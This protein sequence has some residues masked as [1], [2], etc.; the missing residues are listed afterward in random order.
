MNGAILDLAVAIP[1]HFVSHRR[2]AVARGVEPEKYVQGLGCEEMAV[3]SPGEDTVSLAAEAGWRLLEHQPA[4]RERIGLCIV[5]TESGV[6]A[7]K[8][9]AIY[10]HRLLNLPPNCR[11]FEI[12]HACYGATAALQMASAWVQQHPRQLALVIAS[13]I[14]RYER[15]SAGEPT[16]GAGAVALLI[17]QADERDALLSLSPISGAFANDVYDFWRPTYQ[18]E[19]LVKGKYSMNCY[20]ESLQGAYEDY[21]RQAGDEP[22]PDYLLFH[23]PFPN[24]ARKAHRRMSELWGLHEQLIEEDFTQRVEP[25][26]WANRKI[27]NVYSGSLYLAL[28]S[29]C[30]RKA[31]RLIGRRVALFSYGSG[32]CSEYFTGRFGEGLYRHTHHLQALLDARIEVDITRYEELHDSSLFMERNDSHQPDL[33]H[34]GQIFTF[35]GIRDHERCYRQNIHTPTQTLLSNEAPQPHTPRAFQRI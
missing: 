7:A 5:G 34:K 1:R 29:L 8:P 28:A 23:I 20:L 25:G 15:G 19:A 13:D 26:L 24:M 4:L 21:C 16:Q 6:D 14:A 17:G 10:V 18:S 3:C 27:G 22:S 11:A 12:K 30:E 32:S 35:L 33:A 2:L 31:A 9:V